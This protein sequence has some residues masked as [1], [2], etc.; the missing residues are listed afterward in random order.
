MD[1]KPDSESDPYLVSAT[2][3]EDTLDLVFTAEGYAA[4]EEGLA[5]LRETNP[6]ATYQD[7]LKWALRLTI[8]QLEAESEERK[9][10]S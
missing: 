9:A 1:E 8:A 3:D 7:V 5:V 6:S 2:L 10:I 4:M